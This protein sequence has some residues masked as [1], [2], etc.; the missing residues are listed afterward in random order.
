[1]KTILIT[2][3]GTGIGKATAQLLSKDPNTRLLLIGRSLNNLLETLASTENNSQ[4]V[5]HSVDISDA[6]ALKNFLASPKANLTEHPLESVFANAG[7]GGPNEFG[8]DDRWQQIID[9]NLTGAYN[10]C[11]SSYPWLTKSNADVKNVVLTSSCLARFGVPGQTAYVASKTALTG[12]VR[13]LATTWSR[14]GILINAIAPGWVETSMAKN[15]IQAMAEFEGITYKE[16]HKIQSSILP[17][18]RMSQPIEIAQLVK[19]LFSG[20]QKS[21]VGQTIDIN[22]G[23]WMG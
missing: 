8:P 10:T 17:T 9:I 22:N 16:M 11:M 21:I 7:I 18:G 13:S 2:G 23:S 20:L 3:A 1:M 6:E 14:E 12:L 4:H 15:S 5:A 19:F